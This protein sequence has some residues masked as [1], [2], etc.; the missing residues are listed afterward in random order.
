MRAWTAVLNILDVAWLASKDLL[1][2]FHIM[3]L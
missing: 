2:L 1:D 3:L